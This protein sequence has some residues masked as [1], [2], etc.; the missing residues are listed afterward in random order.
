MNEIFY[1]FFSPCLQNVVYTSLKH[2]SICM[3]L[4]LSAQQ[5]HVAGGYHTGQD[6]S[7]ETA[8]S[9]FSV[10]TQFTYLGTPVRNVSHY[11]Q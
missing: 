2:P 4:I 5:S 9:P 10:S 3:R 7:S 6:S 1:T 11:L 8:F